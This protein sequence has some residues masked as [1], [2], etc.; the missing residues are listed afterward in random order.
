MPS[1]EPRRACRRAASSSYGLPRILLVLG[2]GAPEER[3]PT[4]V[5]QH[6]D[7]HPQ[8]G[9]RV[10]GQPR[11]PRDRHRRRP[12]CGPEGRC[13]VGGLIGGSYRADRNGYT[14]AADRS[15]CRRT[16][17][18]RDSDTRESLQRSVPNQANMTC[19]NIAHPPLGLPGQRLQVL[20]KSTV[21]QCVGHHVRG[22]EE[23]RVH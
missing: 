16:A 9:H 6:R 12:R 19:S 14:G 17:P 22:Q 10:V 5:P 20:G 13:G 4:L 21:R 3:H 18:R 1:R 11:R 8:R 23:A 15:S 2:G 7:R